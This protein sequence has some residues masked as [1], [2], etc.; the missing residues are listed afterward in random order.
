MVIHPL[1]QTEGLSGPLSVSVFA[2]SGGSLMELATSP[3]AA[4]AGAKPFGL[5]VD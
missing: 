3:F 5:V 1:A 2:V 4:P